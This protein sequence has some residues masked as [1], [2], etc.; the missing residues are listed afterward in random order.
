MNYEPNLIMLYYLVCRNMEWHILNGSPWQEKFGT[1][2]ID[3]LLKSDMWA[4]CFVIFDL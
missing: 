4:L 1:E 3:V 2:Q